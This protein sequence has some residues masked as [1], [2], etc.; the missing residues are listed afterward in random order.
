M[1]PEDLFA[2]TGMTWSGF[3]PSDDACVYPYLVPSNMFAS[4]VM[5]YV[6]R[7]FIDVLDDREIAGRAAALQH[8]IDDGLAHHATIRNAA[9]TLSTHTK[10]T[11]SQRVAYG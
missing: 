1:V 4:V 7:I 5:G 11:V 2:V 9:E 10:W 6:Q 8:S 3:R